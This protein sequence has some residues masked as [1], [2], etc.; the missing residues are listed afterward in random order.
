M[1]LLDLVTKDKLRTV[2]VVGIAKN[3][4]KTTTLNHLIGLADT[5]DLS[6][7]LTSTGRDGGRVDILTRLPKPAIHAPEGTLIATAEE[8]AGQGTA[9]LQVVRSTEFVTR[10]GPVVV[11]MVVRA[12]AV[13]IEFLPPE[14]NGDFRR[15]GLLL[16]AGKDSLHTTYHLIQ[17]E[18]A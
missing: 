9:G 1:N 16:R 10:L 15:A 11:Y 17:K 7:G 4:G 13:Q 6:L 5:A 8:V 18:G 3:V 2:S 12:G 14:G